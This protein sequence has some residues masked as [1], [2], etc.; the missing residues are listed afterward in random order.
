MAKKIT[1]IGN[2]KA[3]LLNDD[4]SVKCCLGE[5]TFPLMPRKEYIRLRNVCPFLGT[6]YARD[7]HTLLEEH[8]KHPKNRSDGCSWG[9]CE[10]HKCP[11][12]WEADH[13]TA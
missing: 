7:N 4:G 3:Y 10:W 13:G 11:L 5:V 6:H 8:C 12:N 9:E 1:S 2:G